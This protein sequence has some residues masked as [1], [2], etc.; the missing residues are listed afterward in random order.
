MGRLKDKVAVAEI[1]AY[2]AKQKAKQQQQETVLPTPERL[3]KGDLVLVPTYN[4]KGFE[5]GRQYQINA[6]V[7]AVRK[8]ID[9]KSV[10]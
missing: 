9:R 5:D 4:A 7:D 1:S 6:P 10:V 8:Y 2:A 3:A